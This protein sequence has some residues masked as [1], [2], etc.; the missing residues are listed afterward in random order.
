MVQ[1]ETVEFHGRTFVRYPLSPHRSARVYFTAY[2]KGR[3]VKGVGQLHVEVWKVT[4]G[5]DEVPPGYVVHHV[6]LDPLNNDPANLVC[7]TR[8]EHARLHEADSDRDSPEWL[9][10]LAS[11]R[12]LAAEWHRSEEGRAW[13]SL[14]G[15]GTWVG[16]ERTTRTCEECG[17]QYMVAFADRARCCSSACIQRLYRK[18]RRYQVQ[19]P[20]PVCGTPFWQSKYQP[21]PTACSA[22]CAQQLRRAKERQT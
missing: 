8:K 18:E 11:I 14:H 12:P 1:T 6:D 20:C 7:V 19:V 17:R 4:N 9:A 5:K 2:E 3:R 21:K 10:H 15:R 16:R 22:S 13:H